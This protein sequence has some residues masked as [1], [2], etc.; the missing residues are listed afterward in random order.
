MK[1]ANEYLEIYK[2][3]V[4]MA[5]R[6]SARRGAT[7]VYFITLESTLSASAG[8][9]MSTENSLSYQKALVIGVVSL[10]LSMIWWLQIQTYRNLSKA[11]FDVIHELEQQLT[12]APFTKEWEVVNGI[13][14]KHVDLTR[15]ESF[16]PVIFLL[17][18]IILIIGAM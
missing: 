6:L 10:I 14:K 11:K 15:T 4:E 16:I 7:N 9:W 12:F 1:T 5:D 8:F 18:N 17:V 2:L 3:S 13:R